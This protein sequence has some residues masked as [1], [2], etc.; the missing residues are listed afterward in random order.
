M[1][2]DHN[3]IKLEILNFQ[4]LNKT[5]L[6]N[7]WVKEVSRGNKEIKRKEKLNLI[8]RGTTLNRPL[9]K[10]RFPNSWQACKK[11][12]HI[13]TREIQIQMI[14]LFKWQFSVVRK[15][16]VDWNVMGIKTDT[17]TLENWQHLHICICYYLRHPLL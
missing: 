9:Y 13:I 10:K 7:P 12:L 2:S 11:L 15:K 17:I 14:T 16:G 5:V 6:N 1:F 4:R 3:V 8:K